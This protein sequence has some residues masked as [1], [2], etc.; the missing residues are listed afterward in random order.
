MFLSPKHFVFLKTLILATL[1]VACKS[2]NS[3]NSQVYKSEVAALE[4]LE[5]K[6]IFLTNIYSVYVEQTKQSDYAMDIFGLNSDEHIK[7]K[8]VYNKTVQKSEGRIKAY[9]DL[10]GY[11][12]LMK[13]GRKA[14]FAPWVIT[15]KSNDIQ[16]KKS[17]FKFLYDAYVFGDIDD[18]LFM[19]YLT[20]LYYR[21]NKLDY[22]PPKNES[23]KESIESIMY[24]LNSESW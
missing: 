23:T 21:I 5:D 1:L 10:F 7:Q 8:K 12:S 2:E 4:T 3:T 24:L 15:Y 20:D 14:A 19:V 11:P 17:N 16:F 6:E 9:L 18:E 13:L 22:N